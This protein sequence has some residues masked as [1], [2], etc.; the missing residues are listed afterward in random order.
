M[1]KKLVTTKNGA[2]VRMNEVALKMAEKHFG[3]S[4][5]SPTTRETPIE[6]LKM[7]KVDITKAV[8]LEPVKVAEV[9]KVPE[10]VLKKVPEVVEVPEVTDEVTVEKPVKKPVTRKKK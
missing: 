3:L 10:V 4:R 1:E 2:Q 6:L 9:I 8:K 5:H 7:P